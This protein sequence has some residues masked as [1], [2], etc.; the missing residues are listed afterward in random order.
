MHCY[1]SWSM[2]LYDIDPGKDCPEIVRMIVEIPK[3]SA[4]QYEY[5]GTLGVFRLDRA[6][7]SAV[8]YP[9]DYGFMTKPG[10]QNRGQ[11][12]RFPVFYRSKD[13]ETL[14]TVPSVPRLGK[15]EN[16]PSVPGFGRRL[17]ISAN[18]S[19]EICSARRPASGQGSI[20]SF[21]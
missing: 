14:E 3:N 2:S 6:L 19:S 20:N 9:G 1:D 8:H 7:Y 13:L 10:T 4:N 12:E 16:L 5:D 21:P 18:C 15:L 11:T 17:N